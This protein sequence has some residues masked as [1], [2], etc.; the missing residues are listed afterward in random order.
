MSNKTSDK[1]KK[2]KR[3]KDLVR[4]VEQVEQRTRNMVFR[5]DLKKKDLKL[6]TAMCIAGCLIYLAGVGIYIYQMF[7]LHLGDLRYA[8]MVVGIALGFGI[9][10]GLAEVLKE[11]KE[12]I[13]RLTS[14]QVT[15]G[16]DRVT[17]LGMA[18]GQIF[19]AVFLMELL[20]RSDM[21]RWVPA[22]TAIGALLCYSGGKTV[23]EAIKE[24]K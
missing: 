6:Y 7:S 24:A 5:I 22:M 2:K 3:E 19:L 4:K 16:R 21:P 15:K 20:A 11:M 14:T 10:S 9:L 12:G 23:S 18:S 17:N 1:A 13:N 8:V